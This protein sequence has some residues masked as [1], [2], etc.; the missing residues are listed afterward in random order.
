MRQILASPVQ[1]WELPNY[2]LE[3]IR[4]D[5]QIADF[6]REVNSRHVRMLK[7]AI[8]ENKFYNNLI[9]VTNTDAPY[10]VFD[11]QHRLSALWLC[12]IEEGL[13]RYNLMLGIYPKE[14]ARLAYRRINM[15]KPLQL[16]HHLKA[17]DDKSNKFFTELEPWLSH[18]PRPDKPLYINMVQC[19]V[20]TRGY[21]VNIE[22][23][24]Y[25]IE[26]TK[27]KEI[28]V[29]KKVCQA[30]SAHT[31]VIFGSKLYQSQIY[32]NLYKAAYKYNLSD[33]QITRLIN[34]LLKDKQIKE[35]TQF[36]KH[37]DIINVYSY[38]EEN[39]IQEV[40]K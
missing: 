34:L 1:W 5:F 37:A 28:E 40:L 35:I 32:R 31:P 33:S 36:R 6:E 3:K 26:Q 12:H 19:M 7:D 21:K 11:G 29:A 30:A 14:Y 25:V 24:D 9:S 15:G 13:K 16:K 20:Y 27:P 8:M 4:D 2:R 23:I 10:I 18:H 17:L 38:L 22:N 39:L